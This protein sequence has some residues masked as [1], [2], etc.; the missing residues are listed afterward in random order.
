MKPKV[1]FI[2]GVKNRSQEL[3]EMIQSLID[4]D[5]PEWEAIIIDDHSEEDIKSVIESFNDERLRYFRQAEDLTG[6]SNARNFAINQAQ[7]EIMLTA[8]GD[9]V[10]HPERARITY[11]AMIENNFDV[12]YTNLNDYIP[13]QG[14][15]LPRKFQPF[16]AE[17][18]KMFNF[19]TNPGTA[20]K[21]NLFL[22]VGGFDPEFSL[23]E[24]Y[25]LWLRMLNAGAK[26]GYTDQILVDYRRSSGSVTVEKHDQMHQAVMQ[27]RIK[28]NIP[29]FNVNDVSKYALPEIAADLMT[30][31]GHDFWKD[32]RFEDK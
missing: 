17:L 7:T 3:R 12:F 25:D 28:N 10:S 2:T 23:S 22:E 11:N 24:D 18:F 8:D 30:Q 13:D 1:S 29:P 27:T 20:Y 14:K 31:K 26:F 6:I 16:S 19:I 5:M 21:K 32:D 15:L 4:Q 9:D